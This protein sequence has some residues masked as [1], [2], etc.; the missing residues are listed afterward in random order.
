M[1]HGDTLDL[2]LC[3]SSRLVDSDPLLNRQYDHASIPGGSLA[4]GPNLVLTTPSCL[5]AASQGG[6]PSY[7]ATLSQISNNPHA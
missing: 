7:V 4:G 1:L 6:P 5:A 2:K 3:L